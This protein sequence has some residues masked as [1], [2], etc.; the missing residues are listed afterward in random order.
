MKH[1]VIKTKKMYLRRACVAVFVFVMTAVMIFSPWQNTPV[2]AIFPTNGAILDNFNRADGSLSGSTASSGITWSTG[3][4]TSGTNLLNICSD[5]L[6]G[7]NTNGVLSPTYGP[8][9]EIYAGVPVLPSSSGGG[10]VFI[11]ERISNVGTGTWS[12]YGMLFAP[13]NT[14]QL[15]SYTGGSSTTIASGTQVVSAGDSIGFSV[16]GSTLTAWYK[17]VASSWS[18]VITATD[19]THSNA[20]PVG[21]EMGDSVGRLDNLAGGSTVNNSPPAA[22]TL[23][24]PANGATGVSTTPQFQL[25]TTDADNDYLRYKIDVC[26]V[27]DCSSIVRTIDETLS[28]T[29]WSGQDQQAGTAYTG[30]SIITSSTM[31]TYAY[32][33]PAL[34][35]N[36]QYWWRAYAIDPG[37]T[38]TFSGASGI[39]DFTT[40]AS[41]V[42]PVNP[43]TQASSLPAQY[44]A[45]GGASGFKGK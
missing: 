24:A 10:Y 1:K 32:Q 39:Q 17:P 19:S 4:I 36:T 35:P 38:N 34:S 11:A 26:S 18:S 29:G 30:N 12:G 31:A 44:I 40:T 5:Q 41:S 9:T 16:I 20:G 21:I 14:W 28:Q 22:P 25:R 33:A 13:S 27:P 43:A 6:C 3:G 23:N 8:D 45:P 2:Y 15:R 37:G 42:S 7:V